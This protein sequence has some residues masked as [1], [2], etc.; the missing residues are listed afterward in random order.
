MIPGI[1]WQRLIKKLT[2]DDN[3]AGECL[4]L[5]SITISLRKRMLTMMLLQMVYRYQIRVTGKKV[6]MYLYE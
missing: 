5:V 6:V 4:N 1:S 3:A 2:M